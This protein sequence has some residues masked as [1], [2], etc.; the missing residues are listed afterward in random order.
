VRILCLC[1]TY[2]R[3]RLLA[4]AIACF[5]AQDYQDAQLLVLDDLGQ[6]EP[7]RGERW[8]VLSTPNRYPSLPAKYN[9]MLECWARR[10]EGYDAVAVW[11]D[12]DI[13]L[14]WHLSASAAALSDGAP[15]AKP[16]AVW[17]GYRP[18]GAQGEGP[19]REHA[20]GRFHGSL[21]IS[22]A[23]L[24][25]L[26]GW[27]KT[28]RADFDQQ[29]IAACLPAVDTLKHSPHEL[30]GY[31]F[32]WGSTGTPHCQG[33]MSSPDNEDWYERYQPADRR[34]VNVLRQAMDPE[35]QSIYSKIL[36]RQEVNSLS[37]QGSPQFS[38]A[39]KLSGIWKVGPSEQDNVARCEG[40]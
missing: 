14:P 20:T 16:S 17:S 13:Y 35:T 26:G 28:K 25:S 29:Q 1:P 10:G 30:P 2:G 39:S 36:D 6:I 15:S 8:E 32:R 38:L 21:A 27:I 3:P 34:R 23:R 5:E 33:L 12:D 40:P 31:V 37:R 11:D 7:Q 22:R 19:W 24:E 9:A 4:N 18:P